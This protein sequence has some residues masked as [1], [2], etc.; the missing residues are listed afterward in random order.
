MKIICLFLCLFLFSTISKA[1]NIH[2]EATWVYDGTNTEG[3]FKVQQS[4]P[5][6]SIWFDVVNLQDVD[7]R[8]YEWDMESK[9]GE[10]LFR[11]MAYFP[12]KAIFSNEGSFNFEYLMAPKIMKF[13]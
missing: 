9:V 12:G 3:G 13:N 11:I 7:I 8:E 2:V 5:G 1:E 10:T 6:T 4:N